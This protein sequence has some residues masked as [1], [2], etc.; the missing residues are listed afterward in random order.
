M[1]SFVNLL[2]TE[3]NKALDILPEKFLEYKNQYDD[4]YNI[5]YKKCKLKI[6]IKTGIDNSSLNLNN[7]KSRTL[8]P[9]FKINSNN[10]NN[11][12]NSSMS[13]FID[14]NLSHNNNLFSE[15]YNA[16][17]DLGKDNDNVN[18]YKPE[19][20][21]DIMNEKE[22]E[23]NKYKNEVD[24]IINNFKSKKEVISFAREKFGDEFA[25]LLD[26]NKK[27]AELKAIVITELNK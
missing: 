24:N 12:N 25:D 5:K 6:N 21:D 17:I 16:Q 26:E 10:G 7:N 2:I 13:P 19:D 22:K 27:L 15:S 11:K 14:Q 23:L 20:D 8:T 18:I 3:Q 1:S 4:S 9:F